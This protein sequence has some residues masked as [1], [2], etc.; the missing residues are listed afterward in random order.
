MA[1]DST[2]APDIVR[3]FTDGA[4][5]GNPGPGGWA[6]IL[7][8]PASG[9][10]MDASGAEPTTTNNRMELTG[11]IEGLATLRRP[12]RVELI[13]DSQ[14]VAKGIAEWMPKWKSQGWQRKE[15]G[16]LKPVMNVDL[17]QRIDVLLTRH[18][19]RVT[20]VLGHNGHPENEACDRMAVAA[21]K[22]LKADMRG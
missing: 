12:C 17:W 10:T 16:R 11:A 20:H 21:Y 5:S 13:T 14:Y 4:C 7:K 8:H 15:G 1:T 18:K 6:Y 19:V 9:Q 3:L 2:A 22:A